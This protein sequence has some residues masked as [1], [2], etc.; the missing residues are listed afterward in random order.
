[1]N[2]AAGVIEQKTPY[3]YVSISPEDRQFIVAASIVWQ[4]YC[5]LKNEMSV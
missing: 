1:M 3:R 4:H 2:S 5:V